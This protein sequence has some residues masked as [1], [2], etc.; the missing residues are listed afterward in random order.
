MQATT[1]M[2]I[3]DQT[4]ACAGLTLTAAKAANF[5]AQAAFYEG[6][7]R[8]DFMPTTAKV[9]IELVYDQQTRKVLGGQLM[10]AHEVSQSANTLSVV[11]HNGNT[12]D[13]LAFMDMLF[14]PT[15][16]NRLIT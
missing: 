11:I 16:M 5:D 3:F 9:M 13:E 10:S 15:L 14:S 4:V 7:Y 2:W 1:G 6:N 8:P 12:I